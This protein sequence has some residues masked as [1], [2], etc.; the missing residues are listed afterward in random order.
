[1]RLPPAATGRPVNAHDI[2]QAIGMTPTLMNYG[3]TYVLTGAGMEE[4][5]VE[6][7]TATP[8]MGACSAI[9]PLLASGPPPPGG[10]RPE[11]ARAALAIDQQQRDL[12][13]AMATDPDR[14]NTT[15][16]MATQG[17]E[18]E[19]HL[20]ID[21]V[22]QGYG[23]AGYLPP[24]HTYSHPATT[25]F[26]VP[27]SAGRSTAWRGSDRL[28]DL[29]TGCLLPHPDPGGRAPAWRIPVAL[30]QLL[31]RGGRA[32]PGGDRGRR[33]RCVEAT[34]GTQLQVG[35]RRVGIRGSS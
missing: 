11:A 16:A 29:L 13:L 26:F 19:E 6:P 3:L 21:E 5:E 10:L 14:V 25:L 35:F 28:N 4:E 23:M 33:Q 31:L 22:S 2:V 27:T 34:S 20:T 12:A 7:A 15:M 1:M 24:S 30:P 8:H 32:L 17:E 9:T 18:E